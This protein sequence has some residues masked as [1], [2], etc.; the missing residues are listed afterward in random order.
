MRYVYL[1]LVI[2][3]A[4]VP[5]MYFYAW[6]AEHGWALGPMIDA[7]YV[8]DATSALVYDLTI[9]AV[10]L[11]VW[12]LVEAFG[13]RDWWFLLVIP[14]TFGIGVSCGLPLALFLK[15]RTPATA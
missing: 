7:W 3:G 10:A 1:L 4:I 12:A 11:T 13:K 6:F 2:V 15:T 9:A 8:N 14:A 5:W